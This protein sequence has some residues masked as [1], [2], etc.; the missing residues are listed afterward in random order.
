MSTV[1]PRRKRQGQSTWEAATRNIQRSPIS[2]GAHCHCYWLEAC[3]A[4]D[5][6]LGHFV[7]RH[8]TWSPRSMDR[9]H[10]GLSWILYSRKILAGL[11][12][13]GGMAG[14][15]SS[16]VEVSEASSSWGFESFSLLDTLESR[17]LSVSFC[18]R[19]KESLKPACRVWT[20]KNG[21]SR[22]YQ[23]DGH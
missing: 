2:S 22:T 18:R 21:I 20:M 9:C 15:L 17:F 6:D 14:T 10:G 4:W 1:L 3:A 12:K 16:S 8:L 5:G 7:C 13:S 11:S 23:V 19:K